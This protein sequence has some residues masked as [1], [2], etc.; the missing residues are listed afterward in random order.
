MRQ[1]CVRMVP[2]KVDRENGCAWV[3]QQLQKQSF[4]VVL[5]DFLAHPQPN[6]SAR[7][8]WS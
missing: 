8:S 2:A 4:A 1:C 5:N 6:P 3:S 7:S